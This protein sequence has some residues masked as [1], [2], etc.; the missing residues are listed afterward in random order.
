MSVYSNRA[1]LS[2]LNMTCEMYKKNIEIRR[3][4]KTCA[5]LMMSG[6]SSEDISKSIVKR[7][8]N[9]QKEDGGFIGNTDTIWNIV[10]L[11]FFHEYVEERQMAIRW[12]INGNGDEPGYGRSKRDMHR[13][14]VTGL[15]LYLL[16]EVSD[17]RTLSWLEETWYAER[18]SLTYKAAY[19]LLA[20][21]SNNY[22]PQIKDIIVETAEWLDS[23]QEQDGGFGPWKGHPVGTNVYCTSV[24]L[25]ALLK[26]DANKYRD[27]IVKSY[28]YLCKTQ[29]KSGIWP[30]HEIEEGAS[31]GVLALTEVESYLGKIE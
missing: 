2:L 20:F 16:P 11:G 14:P 12:L 5:M 18:N 22:T 28:D 26:T 25:L 29:L 8:L 6:L 4:T 23:Q 9:S 1:M 10:F 3:I 13:I 31:W 19:T 7:C 17:E 21:F 30:Y 15:A 24:A 27:S